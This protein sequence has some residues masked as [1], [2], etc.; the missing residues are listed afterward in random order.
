MSPAPINCQVRIYLGGTPNAS[1][2]N[3]LF[4]VVSE[5][6]GNDIIR[7]VSMDPNIF[8]IHTQLPEKLH[9]PFLRILNGKFIF[10]RFIVLGLDLGISTDERIEPTFIENGLFYR[11][12]MVGGK[13]LKALH[14]YFKS[15]YET[16]MTGHTDFME[17]FLDKIELI[18]KTFYKNSERAYY[19]SLELYDTSLKYDQI[20]AEKP[21]S[22]KPV[23]LESEIVKDLILTI[24]PKVVTKDDTLEL[25]SYLNKIYQ[26]L[27]GEELII[28]EDQV[29]VFEFKNSNV[30]A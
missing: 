22:D 13:P 16:L 7:F 29:R 4:K 20:Q 8:T 2:V 9:L 30:L 6:F 18:K 27:G 28:K 21:L 10:E 17:I 1:D 15:Y 23:L 19:E 5:L 26:A 14:D 12:L 3:R 25:L 11:T 24:D